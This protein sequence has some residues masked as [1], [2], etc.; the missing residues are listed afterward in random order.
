M[1]RNIFIRGMGLGLV[2]GSV[3]G[4]ACMPRRKK[5]AMGKAL[6]AMGGI[7]DNLTDSLGL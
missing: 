4:M 6:K 5:S 2:V 3:V 7:V 1:N